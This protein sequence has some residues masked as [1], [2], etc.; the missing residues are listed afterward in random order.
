MEART[1]Q[2]V[3]LLRHAAEG[4]CGVG[5]EGNGGRTATS[6]QSPPSRAER[7]AR[8]KRKKAFATIEELLG[9]SLSGSGSTASMAGSNAREAFYQ[10]MADLLAERAKMREL[11]EKRER[12][13]VFRE[14]DRGCRPLPTPLHFSDDRD[15]ERGSNH[16][17]ARDAAFGKSPLPGNPQLLRELAKNMDEWGSAYI[18]GKPEDLPPIPQPLKKEPANDSTNDECERKNEANDK[19]DNISDAHN[20]S[21]DWQ[22]WQKHTFGL[23]MQVPW[24][25]ALI[26][27]RKTIETRSYDLPSALLNRRIVILES[28]KGQA[29]VSA[30][31]DVIN[32]TALDEDSHPAMKPIGWCTFSKVIKYRNK[33]QFE[34]D[35]SAH[36][37]SSDSG[38]GWVEGR[39]NVIYGWVVS[40]CARFDDSDDDSPNTRYKSAVRRKRSIYELEGFEGNPK[41]KGQ[42]QGNKKGRNRGGTHG[43]KKRRRY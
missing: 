4:R 12:D 7:K 40:Q 5:A 35:V 41:G 1:S 23:E 11:W 21:S 19:I 36:Q 8:E 22:G 29:G 2:I 37:V 43:N 31:G 3:D 10:P 38:Y 15:T 32:L 27:G 26:D 34:R 17:I 42:K 16:G 20:K 33:K 39:T 9:R 14:M 18:S 25:G 28:P 24:A 30:M 6:T 13:H